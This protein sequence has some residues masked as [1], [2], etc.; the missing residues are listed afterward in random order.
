MCSCGVLVHCP[1]RL[2]AAVTILA[3]ELLCGHGMFAD[4]TLERAKTVHQCDGVV[5]HN[6][7]ACGFL[8]SDERQMDGTL[9]ETEILNV[10]KGRREGQTSKLAEH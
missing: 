1:S 7:V 3:I 9:V 6:Y 10:E 2:G 4:R 8:I 5:S